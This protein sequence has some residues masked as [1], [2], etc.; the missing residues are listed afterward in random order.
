MK[1]VII[2][3]YDSFTFNLYHYLEPMVD[4]LDVLRNDEFQME[5]IASY[6]AIVLSPGPG[7]P[8]EAGLLMDLI[9]KYHTVKPILGVCLGHQALG[10]YFGASLENL[11][12][13]LHGQPTECEAYENS[14]LFDEC[15]RPFLI[16]H[17]HS[18]VIADRDLP[19]DI[20]VTARNNQGHIMAIKHKSL[21]LHGLQFHPESIL[22]PP[23]KKILSNWV[24]GVKRKFASA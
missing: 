22:S 19:V 7:L 16:G 4:Q 15:E 14:V 1:I 12:A 10:E 2:D 17:Y 13:V 11:P 21:P 23:G 6:D 20:E 24:K 9:E 3:N 18:W 8:K 5:E